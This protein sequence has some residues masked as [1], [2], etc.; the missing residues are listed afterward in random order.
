MVWAEGAGRRVLF[1]P[2]P[3]DKTVRDLEQ[4]I[5][6]ELG[7]PYDVSLFVDGFLVPSNYDI[8]ILKDDEVITYAVCLL[9]I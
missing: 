7:A 4:R 8:S 1:C 5:C 3:S 9:S 2:F 6:H